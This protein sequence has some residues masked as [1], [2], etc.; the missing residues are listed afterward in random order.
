MATSKLQ[1]RSPNMVKPQLPIQRPKLLI[2]TPKINVW[3][4]EDFV[5][6]FVVGILG[7]ILL[8]LFILLLY[9]LFGA[10]VSLI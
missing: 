3:N 2:N 1:I 8:E 7:L 4:N 10:L 5:L 9:G 6:G